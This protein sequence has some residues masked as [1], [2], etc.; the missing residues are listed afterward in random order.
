MEKHVN[1]NF[2]KKTFNDELRSCPFCN[3]SHI[4]Q[5]TNKKPV[6]PKCKIDLFSRLFREKELFEC[7]SCHGVWVDATDFAYLTT[8]KDVYADQSAEP[9]YTKL[10]PDGDGR[11]YPCVRCDNL[12]TP[13]NFRNISGIIIDA[14]YGHGVWLD[15]GELT[16]IRKFIAG[17]GFDASQDVLISAHANELKEITRNLSNVQMI[18]R[19]IH[20]WDIKR[21]LFDRKTF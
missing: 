11:F 9:V 20:F 14:C 1:C 7:Q 15:D 2:C 3:M 19:I 18:Q 12:M 6:C 16:R 4:P 17:G 10:P 13:F 21:I 5:T 8:E